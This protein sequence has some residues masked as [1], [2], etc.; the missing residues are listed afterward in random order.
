M[1]VADQAASA[2]T[3]MARKARMVARIMPMV[4]ISQPTAMAIDA[5]R[6]A[7]EVVATTKDKRATTMSTTVAT[8]TIRR[9]V[10]GH[11]LPMARRRSMV[12]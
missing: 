4:I 1:A 8:A 6:P 5:P 7:T 3:T 10:D 11:R 2:T 12:A 9:S